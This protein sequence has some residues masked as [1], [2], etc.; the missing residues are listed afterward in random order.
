MRLSSEKIQSAPKTAHELVMVKDSHDLNP[1]MVVQDRAFL[2]A[3][4]LRNEAFHDQ[5]DVIESAARD[6]DQVWTTFVISRELLD[7]FCKKFKVRGTPTFL[8]Y[9]NGIEL[10]RILGCTTRESLMEFIN[11]NM[12][13][14]DQQ[15]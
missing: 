7:C 11:R 4:M 9:W 8:L 1:V 6:C 14:I 2:I 12:E 10:D 3:C 13:T 15:T 5:L